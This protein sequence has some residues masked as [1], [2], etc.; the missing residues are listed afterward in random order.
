[1]CASDH[2]GV[3]GP[4]TTGSCALG[5]RISLIRERKAGRVRVEG[6]DDMP[7][8]VGLVE[9]AKLL[10]SPQWAPATCSSS[11]FSIWQVHETNSARAR[12]NWPSA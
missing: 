4:P 3:A 9:K 2:V 10:C 8:S 7:C 5:I 6:G 11:R 1:V 12:R